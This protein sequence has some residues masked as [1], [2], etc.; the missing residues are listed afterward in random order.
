MT[1]VF[2]GLV[3]YNFKLNQRL[4]HTICTII[5]Y[6]SHTW[7][8][9]RL[10]HYALRRRRLSLGALFTLF[11]PHFYDPEQKSVDVASTKAAHCT[12]GEKVPRSKSW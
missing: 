9:V 3:I 2:A 6:D 7:G 12:S 10:S 4:G 8:L 5:D 11:H 1:A